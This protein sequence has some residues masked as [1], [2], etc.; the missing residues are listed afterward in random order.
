M[1]KS[2]SLIQRRTHDG[3]DTTIDFTCGVS[4]KASKRHPYHKD[5]D[6]KMQR[7]HWLIC[8]S[9]YD[10]NAEFL[11]SQKLNPSMQKYLEWRSTNWA[12]YFAEERTQPTSSSSWTP[13]SSGLRTGI[14]TIGK[15]ASGLK[16]GKMRQHRLPFS[17]KSIQATGNWLSPISNTKSEVVDIDT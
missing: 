3:K 1:H 8:R 11:I 2:T 12:E 6:A 15:T 4:T 10:K 13:S 7:K 9:K 14:S 5:Q 17:M 16:N